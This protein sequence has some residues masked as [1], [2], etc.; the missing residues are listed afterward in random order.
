M[1][2]LFP[3]SLLPAD[4]I[5]HL[6]S[7]LNNPGSFCSQPASRSHSLSVHRHRSSK[8]VVKCSAVATERSSTVAVPSKAEDWPSPSSAPRKQAPSSTEPSRSSQ[9]NPQAR[10]PAAS[11]Q[12][13][14]SSK[15]SQERR[16]RPRKSSSA[17]GSFKLFPSAAAGT[18]SPTADPQPS[19]ARDTEQRRRQRGRPSRSPAGPGQ[20]RQAAGQKSEPSSGDSVNPQQGARGVRRQPLQRQQRQGQPSQRSQQYQS[21][22]PD[23]TVSAVRRQRS[24]SPP[25]ASQILDAADSPGQLTLES[26]RV[27]CLAI[28]RYKELS[29]NHRPLIA[30]IFNQTERP[31]NPRKTVSGWLKASQA[32]SIKEVYQD[33][34]NGAKASAALIEKMHLLINNAVRRYSASSKLIDPNEMSSAAEEAILIAAE[35]FDFSKGTRFPTLA[36]WYVRAACVRHLQQHSIMHVP[37]AVQELVRRVQ[38]AVKSFRE[39]NDGRTPSQKQIA[40]LT[41]L[42]MADV[43]AAEEQTAAVSATSF[44]MSLD[45][46][47]NNEAQET[48]R[49]GKAAA[50][51][52]ESQS[53]S[54]DLH[55]SLVQDMHILLDTAIPAFD[56]R[57]ALKMRYGLATGE[58]ASYVKIART[59]GISNASAVTVV[60]KAFDT[61]RLQR[62]LWERILDP[63][64]QNGYLMSERNPAHDPTRNL[65]DY[66]ACDLQPGTPSP[67]AKP[68]QISAK[69]DF[70]A[71]LNA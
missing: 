31:D 38:Q 35:K 34:S 69:S 48:L 44:P 54:S 67:D 4:G 9:A 63:Y 11:E 53:A 52:E 55:R 49:E 23:K 39:D 41:G 6:A 29:E 70:A 30:Y 12:A 8:P 56:Q 71:A 19:Q 43:K 22:T 27:L 18:S 17:A 32:A 13:V 61:L 42:S 20:R 46:P 51:D 62:P 50:V 33:M 68:P 37:K 5:S 1:A 36:A 25:P 65:G 45:E 7:H 59:L 16:G 15:P 28:K 60:Q 64:I 57:Q 14:P 2:L 21:R 47:S 40:E 3:F 58:P 10:T 66:F 26:E 24:L